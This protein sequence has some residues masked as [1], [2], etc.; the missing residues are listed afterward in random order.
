MENKV[1]KPKI[2]FKGFVDTWEQR[3]LGEIAYLRGRIGFRGY[4]RTDLV[5]EGKGA[6]TF[7]PS[8]IDDEGHLSL[9]NNTYISFE[10]YE[11]SPEIKVKENDIL[12]TKTASIGKIAYVPK[13]K[14]KSTINPQFALITPD[15]KINPYFLFL[16]VRTDENIKYAKDITGGSTIPTMSQEKLKLMNIIMPSSEEQQK[17][18]TFFKQLDHLI[19]LH[20]Q[21]IIW[22]RI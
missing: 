19:T 14:G 4:K 17:I 21:I 1:L 10:K 9:E 11:E 20:Q 3:K 18:G 13:L 12:F 16:S 15:T 22:R 6:I 7:S 8:D 2:R 5:E